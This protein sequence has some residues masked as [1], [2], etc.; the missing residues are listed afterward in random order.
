MWYNKVVDGCLCCLQVVPV[1]YPRADELVHR[2]VTQF[3]CT[4]EFRHYL[5]DG[6]VCESVYNS[7]EV[8]SAYDS[9]LWPSND[10]GG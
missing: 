1:L 3:M 7:F 4:E 5:D 10:S 2:S 8:N 9:D 6:E